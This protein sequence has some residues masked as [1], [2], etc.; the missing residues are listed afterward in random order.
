MSECDFFIT[1][2]FEVV[3]LRLIQNIIVPSHFFISAN[4]DRGETA[5]DAEMELAL[6]KARYWFENVVSKC[7][8]FGR[9]NTVAFDMLIEDDGTPRVGN[10]FMLVPD[11]PSDEMLGAL[12]QS[13]MNALSKGAFVVEAL[14]IKSDNLAGISFTLVGDPSVY[15]PMTMEEWLAGPS[16][17]EQPWWLRDDASTF[18]MYAMDESTRNQKPSWAFSLD[19][20]DKSKSDKPMK[21]EGAS[22]IR[23]SFQPKVI[24]GGKDDPEPK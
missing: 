2:S 20:L 14:E 22:V 19:F 10:L 24:K 5:T 23:P 15:L 16:F 13:K 11:S 9:D 18:D 12:F 7:I 6:A 4:L 21:T 1:Y 8:A 17:F 3:L